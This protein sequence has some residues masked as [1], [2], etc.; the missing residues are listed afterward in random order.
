MLATVT[1]RRGD[2]PNHGANDGAFIHP[3]TQGAYRDFRPSLTSLASTLRLPLRDDIVIDAEPLAWMGASMP[4]RAPAPVRVLSGASGWLVARHRRALLF[5]R[6]GR[7]RSRPSHLDRMHVDLR[8]DEKPLLVDA[9]TF[10]YNGPPPWTG[11]L[12]GSATHNGPIVDGREPGVRG[13]RF[14]WLRWPS[15]D[16]NGWRE[17]EDGVDVAASSEDVERIIRLR[18]DYVEILD[19]PLL[20]GRHRVHVSWLLAPGVSPECIESSAERIVTHAQPN[21]VKGWVSWYY[22]DRTQSVA[23][24]L[25]AECTRDEPLRTIVRFPSPIPARLDEE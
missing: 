9:G 22:G 25:D 12:G 4:L 5:L 18:D 11:G 3:V 21:A 16:I 1:D 2:V 8:V 24:D 13:P 23:V 10:T 19:R 20:T 7:Y 15:A 17:T 6:A 14:L